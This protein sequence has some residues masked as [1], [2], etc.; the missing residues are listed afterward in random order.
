MPISPKK[1]CTY[2]YCGTLV[3]GGRCDKHQEKRKTNYSHQLSTT[4]RGYGNAWRKLR[5]FVLIR[6]NNLCQ[7]CLTTGVLTEAYAVDHI[8][9]KAKG[10]GD[11]MDNLQAICKHCH[12]TKTARDDSK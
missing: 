11:N 3:K 2:P 7:V 9:P 10:G 4:E 8:V 5:R 12:D 6:D 1:P